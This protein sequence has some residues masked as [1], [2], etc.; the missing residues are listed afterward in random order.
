MD[1]NDNSSRNENRNNRRRSRKLAVGWFSFTCS[2]DS[3][4]ILL[5]LMNDKFFEWKDLID[6]KAF[7]MLGRKSNGPFDVVFIEGAISLKRHIEKLKKLRAVSKRLVAVGSCAVT[8][9]PSAQRNLFDEEKRNEIKPI[10]DKFGHL[11]KVMA[12][13]EVVPV[14]ASIPGCPMDP[15]A[16]LSL[17]EKYLD[18]FEIKRK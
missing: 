5:E 11:D 4:I 17:L 9:M 7:R 16:F 13:H 6:F 2:E 12:V 1:N 15:N 18:E 8:G 14:D 10:L 3:S